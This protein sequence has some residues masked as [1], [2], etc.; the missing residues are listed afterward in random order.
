MKA[1]VVVAVAGI[2]TYL[3]RVSML[4]LSARRGLPPLLERAARFAVPTAFAAL[5]VG[6]LASYSASHAAVAPIAA[7]VVAAITVHHTRLPYMALV[8]GMPTL[9]LM[10]MAV[11]R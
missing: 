1:F 11:P 8:A 9:W 3:L 10:S 7:V 5:A 6:S 4:V 2:G